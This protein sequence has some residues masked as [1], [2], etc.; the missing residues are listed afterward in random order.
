MYMAGGSREGS[1]FPQAIPFYTGRENLTAAGENI[2]LRA[3]QLALNSGAPP[4]T[5]P[6]APIVFTTQ[7]ADAVV[8]RGG[9]VTL[10]VA[11]TGAAPRTL[12]WQRDLGDG[13]T[14]AAIPG[15][16]TTFSASSLTLSNLDL[17]DSGAKIRVVAGNPNGT[18]TSDVATLTV[19]PD[20]APPVPIGAATV[21]GTSI[22]VCFD[23]LLNPAPSG[24]PA[25]DPFSYI[26][27]DSG[28]VGVNAVTLLQDGRSVL[29][30]LDGV[31]SPGYTLTI[32]LVDDRFGNGI[33]EPGVVLS[34]AHYGLTG[35]D[36]GALNP[37]GS[38]YSCSDASFVVGGGGL[39]IQGTVEQMRL[40]YKMVNG[41]FDAKVRVLSITGVDRLEAVAKAILSA[42]ASTDGAA[43]SVNAFVTTPVP[44]DSTFGSTA[45]ATQGGA[46]SS[47]F[48]TVAYV[49]NSV[50]ATFPAWLRIRRSGDVF[51]TF[52]G[53][54]GTD[55]TQLGS[56]TV[57][58]GADVLVGAGANSHRNGRVA[59]ATFA[60]FSISQ[61]PPSPTL[62]GLTYA[63]GSFTASFQTQNGV[64]YTVQYKDDL[65]AVSWSTL[66]TVTGDGTVKSFTDPGPAAPQRFYQ[67]VVP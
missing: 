67:I 19:S 56:L 10:S 25:I 6:S 33:P 16:S 54:N 47:N 45:R 65:N 50:P 59:L 38:N 20:D 52:G 11:V 55:W 9:S 63:A 64:N 29:L 18:L 30:G 42:R 46:T 37:A 7:P 23:E 49:P 14:F 36:V 13:M 27:T 39:D 51:T 21:D 24:N 15:A 5:D 60:D 57:A 26:L 28:G 40:A 58:M 62:T 32:S 53:A 12:E 17:I 1:T 66:T 61:P 3:V 31:V 44:G 35:A 4:A 41:D 8:G 48:L 34:G 22:M 43:M 2:F